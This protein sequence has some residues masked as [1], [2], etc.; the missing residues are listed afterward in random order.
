MSDVEPMEVIHMR[1]GERSFSSYGVTRESDGYI[2]V[3][4]HVVVAVEGDAH[5]GDHAEELV[6]DVEGLDGGA[7][8]GVR[9]ELTEH[10]A[11]R[12]EDGEDGDDGDVLQR[13]HG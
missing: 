13:V 2:V 6:G 3:A 8:H 11:H 4:R 12:D 1:P 7:H 10:H 9:D 5:H